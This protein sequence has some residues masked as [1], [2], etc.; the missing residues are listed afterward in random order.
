MLKNAL[1]R[2]GIENTWLDDVHIVPLDHIEIPK[3]EEVRPVQDLIPEALKNR[4]EIE[5]SKL[6]IE[7]QKIM[8]KGNK[9][10]AAAEPAGVRRVHQP[11]TERSG[12]P[13]LQQ[14]LRRA[15]RVLPRRQRQC[16]VADFPAQLP[17]LFGGLL[18]E[19]P[20]P[21]P[22]R[23]GGLRD[24]P[25]AVAAER[26]AVAALG[27]PGAGRREDGADRTAAGAGAV[28]DRGRYAGA[29][30]AEPG[31]REKRFQA[32]VATASRW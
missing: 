25:V 32:G 7:S 6:N 4:L 2:N 1:S 30:R 13:A 12:Q 29:L 31:G 14:L 28:P 3:T 5:R 23:A 9:N 15:E 17:G 27:E 18:A 19:H 24:R 8:L 22:R 26:T 21:Q 16:A 11:R 10:G 20:V